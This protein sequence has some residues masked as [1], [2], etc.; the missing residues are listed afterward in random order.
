ME[1]L[2][3]LRHLYLP[4]ELE[5]YPFLCIG[6][7]SFSY[8]YETW[9]DDKKV[10]VKIPMRTSLSYICFERE[11]KILSKIKNQ[12]ANIIQVCASFLPMEEGKLLEL[13]EI[14]C[15]KMNCCLVMEYGGRPLYL[16]T[17]KSEK[18]QHHEHDDHDDHDDDWEWKLPVLIQVADALAYLHKH[19]ICHRDIKSE[20]ILLLEIGATESKTGDGNNND[21]KTKKSCKK[22]YRAVLCDFGFAILSDQEK[23]PPFQGTTRCM[24][25]EMIIHQEYDINA[26][27]DYSAVDVYTFGILLYEILA[28][29]L[30]WDDID[31]DTELYTAVAQG[32]RPTLPVDVG[33][34][35]RGYYDLI[36]KCW[37]QDPSQRPSML[38]VLQCLKEMDAD[39]LED[40]QT[41][42]KIPIGNLSKRHNKHCSCLIL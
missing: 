38:H 4:S 12:H 42:M 35:P 15:D 2:D 5:K 6:K 26:R 22:N 14:N 9:Y 8:V 1:S 24:S 29:R 36:E 30:A 28:Q 17:E 27:I 11:V 7:G 23:N 18:S 21:N 34:C 13:D 32:R 20:N 40:P 41:L 16:Y 19:G 37:H 25:P 39:V 10:A 31:R 33:Q 3:K